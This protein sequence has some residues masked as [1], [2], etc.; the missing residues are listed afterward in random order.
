M[1]LADIYDVLGLFSVLGWSTF[2]APQDAA[3]RAK[4]AAARA[5]EIDP[6]LGEAH[7]SLA[8][9]KFLYDWNW[10]GAEE[11]FRVALALGPNQA[12]GH[13]WYALFLAA[14]GR[15][16]EAIAE[17]NLALTL[18]PLSLAANSHLGWVLYFARRYDQAFD[19]LRSTVEMDPGFPLTHLFL[20]L[21]CIQKTTYREAI[22]ELGKA[23]ESLGHPGVFAEL[24]RR[25]GQALRGEPA[26]PVQD[27]VIS[28]YLMAI[29]H[30]SL[31]LKDIALAYLEQAYDERCCWLVNLGVE[32]ALDGLRSE[33]GFHSLLRRVGL[34]P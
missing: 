6:N 31:G 26:S 24:S 27:D 17:M 11:E 14:M 29:V 22:V 5:L 10:Q 8:F 15:F 28:P 13:C 1:G 3:G 18:D 19:Q 32:P 7:T 9:A 21:T 12:T 2:S 20:G 34:G 33:P 4:A 23:F 16:D 25:Y 30:L